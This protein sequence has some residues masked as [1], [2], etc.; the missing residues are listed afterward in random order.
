MKVVNLGT[1][2]GDASGLGAAGVASGPGWGAGDMVTG[3][4]VDRSVDSGTGGGGDGSTE[5]KDMETI[6]VKP[7]A[8]TK[9]EFIKAGVTYRMERKPISDLGPD[10]LQQ[11]RR[12][13]PDWIN[14][15]GATVWLPVETVY[16]SN[17]TGRVTAIRP[18]IHPERSPG[19]DTRMSIQRLFVDPDM[20]ISDGR[21]AW[22]ERIDAPTHVAQAEP[23]KPQRQTRLEYLQSRWGQMTP[24]EAQEFVGYDNRAMLRFASGPIGDAVDLPLAV[25]Q[26]RYRDAA[27]DAVSLAAPAVVGKTLTLG[28]KFGGIVLGSI[29]RPVREGVQYAAVGIDLQLRR[30]AGPLA[31]RV[32]RNLPGRASG[33]NLPVVTGQWLKG[34]SGVAGSIPGQ[35]AE[36]L[37]GRQFSNFNQFREA[38]W[39]EVASDSVLA[40]QFSNAN[41]RLMLQGRAPFVP[42]GQR[43]EGQFTYVL[44]HKTP[45]ARGGSVYDMNNILVTT[46]RFHG[47]ILDRGFHY[48]RDLR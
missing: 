1:V 24:D 40:P 2:H 22:R 29:W 32:L 7:D 17:Y 33:G 14:D 31:S 26:G 43:A 38:F 12:D 3:G 19:R 6:T 11:I 27:G 10:Q 28:S 44:H 42:P 8:E 36:K 41:Q 47:N 45:I 13:N 23:P 20:R 30:L 18:E 4:G 25:G 34:T 37:A 46:P 21:T 16:T 15:E 9:K 35:V 5:T 39:K 48:S